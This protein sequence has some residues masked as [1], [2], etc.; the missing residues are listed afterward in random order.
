[1]IRNILIKDSLAD[2]QKKRFE[3][4]RLKTKMLI[5]N[6]SAGLQASENSQPFE[7][8]VANHLNSAETKLKMNQQPQQQA[9]PISNR[10]KQK[11]ANNK[12]SASSSA[13]LPP[14]DLNLF[15]SSSNPK[16]L[17]NSSSLKLKS[18]VHFQGKKSTTHMNPIHPIPNTTSTFNNQ[19]DQ[20]NSTLLKLPKLSPKLYQT[21]R[22]EKKYS[23]SP[24]D[25]LLLNASS[26]KFD[27][28]KVNDT[29]NVKKISPANKYVLNDTTT[30]MS[31]RI[32]R[33]T[34]IDLCDLS[35]TT[36]FQTLSSTDQLP[37]IE[38]INK[39]AQSNRWKSQNND[40]ELKF[41]H[42][43]LYEKYKNL[44]NDNFDD[45]V[46]YLS[47]KWNIQPK[48]NVEYYDFKAN[49]ELIHAKTKIDSQS[50]QPL[51]LQSQ[52]QPPNTP[53]LDN[54]QHEHVTKAQ[55][56]MR[57][58]LSLIESINLKINNE[59]NGR[60]SE[61]RTSKSKKTS[62]TPLI[63]DM[64]QALNQLS[65]MNSEEHMNMNDAENESSW[66]TEIE[67]DPIPTSKLSTIDNKLY[68]QIYIP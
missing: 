32:K 39:H 21:N 67:K 14:T 1:M 11:R 18:T 34:S 41:E 58:K 6:K 51:V 54:Q 61:Q 45:Y 33:K 50:K 37:K 57:K 10:I 62:K 36:N 5:S 53:N 26:L 22:V 27:D 63:V 8:L 4:N 31:P 25:E 44:Q 47:Q 46:K 20:S 9:K 42:F 30:N 59:N 38:L 23:Q 17:V 60:F 65:T 19:C 28:F 3:L 48:Y 13:Y 24:D 68:L 56:K 35:E 7:L 55:K 2:Q 40:K 64:K 29:L 52:H 16:F 66:Q 12:F 15:Q 43:F 49:Q